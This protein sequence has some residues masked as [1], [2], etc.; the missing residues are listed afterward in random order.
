MLR[1]TKKQYPE[2][3]KT[4]FGFSTMSWSYSS[5][6]TFMGTFFMIFLTDYSGIDTVLGAAGTAAAFG[7]ILLLIARIVDIVDDPLQ[8]WIIDSSKPGRFGKYRKFNMLHIIAVTVAMIA[9]YGIPGFAKANPVILCIWLGFFYLMYEFGQALYT[10][11]P[12]LQNVTYDTRIRTKL[13]KHFRVWQ[14]FSVVPV[15]FFIP[16]VTSIN[17]SIGNIGKSFSLLT[18]IL[19]VTFGVISLL[20]TASIHENTSSYAKQGSD[21]MISIKSIG[22]M[23]RNNKPLQITLGGIAVWGFVWSLI[24]AIGIY[25]LKWYYCADWTTGAVD[26]QKYAGIYSIYALAMILP[27]FI[28]PFISQLVV[29]KAGSTIKGFRVGVLVGMLV[30]ILFFVMFITGILKISPFIFIGMFFLM[31]FSFGIA[32]IPQSLLWTE[33]ADYAEY[34]EGRKMS[35]IVNSLNSILTKAQ[36]AV[37]TSLTGFILVLVGYSVNASTGAYAGDLA[38]IPK[39]LTGFGIFVSLVPAVLCLLTLLIFSKY[40]LTPEM[41]LEVTRELAARKLENDVVPEQQELIS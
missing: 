25:F 2:N 1:R 18:I 4:T 11:Q 39:M 24:S 36:T 20:G 7:T 33:S 26:A 8:A 38:G 23:L 14:V 34:K 37:T 27:N 28:S 40:P 16:I 13:T 35:A 12:L 10:Y 15:Y 19:M 3:F 30:S 9:L 41:Q 17:G 22:K 29:K 32:F 5:A 21:G 31:G 6:G